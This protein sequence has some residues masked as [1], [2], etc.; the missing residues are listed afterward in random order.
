MKLAL[1]LISFIGLIITSVIFGIV[2]LGQRSIPDEIHLVGSEQINSN[3]MFSLKVSAEELI[4]SRTVFSSA[5][6][7]GSDGKEEYTLNFSLL[8]T[9]PIKAS[10]VTVSQ[11]Q[12]AVPSGEIFGIKLYTD[13]VIITGTDSVECEGRAVNPGREAGLEPGDIITAVNSKKVTK[14]SEVTAFVQN[15]DEGVLNLTVSRNGRPFETQLKLVRS[16]T[17]NCCKAGLWIRDSTAGVGTL[18]YYDK[19]SGVFAGLGH[20]VCD[21]DT[22]A[23]MPLLTGEAVDAVINGCYKGS[24]GVTGELCGVFTVNSLG[25]LYINC[26]NGVYGV[27]DSIPKGK[28]IPVAS[29]Q[30]VQTGPAEIIATVDSESPQHYSIKIV[31]LNALSDKDEKNMVIEV[32]DERLIEKTG[33]IVQGMSGSPIIQNGM[34]VGA[35]THVFVNNSNQGYAIFAENMLATSNSLKNELQNSKMQNNE[36][37][38]SELQK[39]ELQTDKA[40]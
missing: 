37:Q 1:K 31:R 13:G 33:G 29:K 9:I 16:Q 10:S 7:A 28:E 34:L 4:T 20:P 27:L 3:E 8:G 24:N 30:E 36:L 40:S 17:D 12:Y 18:T 21:V 32:T 15:S 22:G 38:N 23:V 14:V 11:R 5:N 19:N 25:K 6:R 39:G 2:F 35:V 26:E